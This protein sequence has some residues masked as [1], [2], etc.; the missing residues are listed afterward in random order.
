MATRRTTLD[1]RV[2]QNPDSEIKNGPTGRH[3]MEN[4]SNLEYWFI[5]VHILIL[6]LTTSS[7]TL[8]WVVKLAK[9]L[10]TIKIE[11]KITFNIFL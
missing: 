7:F 6:F 2:H 4:G 9:P 5:F 8:S 3:Y 11:Y 1:F 10:K